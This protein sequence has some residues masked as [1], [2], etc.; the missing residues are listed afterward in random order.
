MTFGGVGGGSSR[1]PR[2][3]KEVRLSADLL[4]VFVEGQVV[5]VADGDSAGLDELVERRPTLDELQRRA[6][7]GKLLPAGGS[8]IN[9]DGERETYVA[10]R[11]QHDAVVGHGALRRDQ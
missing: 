3:W 2:P 7:R 1:D 4:P 10:R 11:D 5:E 6:G 8:R 9:V